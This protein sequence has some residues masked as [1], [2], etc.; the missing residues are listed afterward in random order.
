[1]RTRLTAG[2]AFC[3]ILAALLLSASMGGWARDGNAHHAGRAAE[4]LVIGTVGPATLSGVQVHHHS[5]PVWAVEGVVGAEPF[6]AV[7]RYDP[8]S[9]EY[10]PVTLT[11]GG[12]AWVFPR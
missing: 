10:R 9:R 3:L 1:M 4:R 8:G 7:L 11:V 5:G 6:N 12:Q 2:C